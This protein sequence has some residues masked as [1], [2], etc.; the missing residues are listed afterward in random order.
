MPLRTIHAVCSHDCPDSCGVLVTIDEGG[1]ATR[2]RGD[3][4]HPVTRGF[5]CGKVAK[6]LDRVYSPDRLLY[7]MRRRAGIPRGPLPWRHE[8]DSFE[9]ISWDEALDTIAARLASVAAEF[10]PESILPYSYAGTIG[11]L[12]YGSMDRRFFHRLGAS[13]L[14]R[15][16]CAETGGQALK[17]VYGQKLGTD[18]EAFRHAKLIIAWAA[19]IHGNNI[20]LWPFVE[21]ARRNGAQLVV[22]DPYATRTAR[23][24]DWHI[25]IRPGTD[26]ALAL[27]MMHI[28]IRDRLY[29]EDYVARWT[30]GFE[31]LQERAA[32]YPPERVEAITG[33]P[34][35]DV[36][37]LARLYG[38]TAPAVIRLNYGVQR[39]D[40]GGAA[41]RAITMLPALTGAWK[42]YGGGLQLSTSGAFR[43]DS[44]TLERPDLMRASPLKRPARIVN[45]STLGEALTK[46]RDPAVHALF[47]YN[48]NPAAVAPDQASVLRGLSRTDLFTVVHEQFFTDTADYA[49][50]VLPAT[51]FLEH[52]DIQGAYGHYYVQLS[53]QAIEPLGEA[54]PNVW[55]FSQ[56]AQRMGFPESCFR[57]TPDD[58]IAQ[59]LG[60]PE[61]GRQDSFMAGMTPETL[62]DA[63]CM[64]RLSL[65]EAPNEQR[66][67]PFA[68]GPF[69]TPSGKIEFYSSALEAQGVDPLPAFQPAPES[70][71]T[72]ACERY[73]LEFLPRKADN[74]MNS[75]FPNLPGHQEMESAY[76]GILEI[77]TSDAAARG[78][79]EGN[80]VDVFNDRGSLRLCAHVNGAVQPGVVAA[81]LNWNKLSTGGHNVNLLTSQRLNDIGGGP[82]FYSVLVDVRRAPVPDAA[83]D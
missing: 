41:V 14:A 16:I 45:M 29:D 57:D 46:L 13:Q 66:F 38:T 39:S 25:P 40:N 17:S 28:L 78:I 61:P 63:G 7:P 65:G 83:R 58:L 22:V 62:T 37:R 19:N 26:S 24:A 74:Y 11:V 21:E 32:S 77:H 42:H 10:G 75:T 8:A 76:N 43:W 3:P 31:P 51:T 34:V 52:K 59:A 72:A 81:R 30:C 54:R 67:L 56:L 55:L 35:A 2:L 23:A 71:H 64:Q 36:E 50:I 20:H 80:D 48:S 47:V 5:L 79:A 1:R 18:T 73:P 82:V 4:A 15:T 27:G 68:Q 53:Q 70:R 44:E 60:L 33:I 69:A 49:D 6:Y 12:G 9:R